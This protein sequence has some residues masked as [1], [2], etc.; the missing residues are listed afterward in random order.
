MTQFLNASDRGG[1]QSIRNYA[2]FPIITAESENSS[3]TLLD[4]CRTTNALRICHRQT[5]VGKIHD[6]DS[7]MTD[8]SADI[9]GNAFH[10][11]R[12]D[13]KS[14]E[15]CIDVHQGSERTCKATPNP[16][17]KPKIAAYPN[18]ACQKHVHEVVIIELDPQKGPAGQQTVV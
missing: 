18:D 4:A 10:L 16:S 2:S 17:A 13:A 12:E 15:S 3:R 8:R 9:A 6:V 14:R 5:L 7:L 11:L 1:F